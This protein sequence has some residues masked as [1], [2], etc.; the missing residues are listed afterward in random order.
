MYDTIDIISPFSS[1]LSRCWH[2]SNHLCRSVMYGAVGGISPFSSHLSRCCRVDSICV[3]TGVWWVS[4]LARFLPLSSHLSRCWHV[5]NHLCRSVVSI[6]VGAISPCWG[7]HPSAGS[8]YDNRFQPIRVVHLDRWV[9]VSPDSLIDSGKKPP[10]SWWCV[11]VT[12]PAP[13]RW[14]R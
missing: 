1:H 10:S 2:V 4:Q 12:L 5:S 11:S 13:S 14:W 3:A 9:L 6:T 7:C 8:V